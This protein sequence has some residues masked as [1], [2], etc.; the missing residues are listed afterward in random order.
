MSKVVLVF[1]LHDLLSL[2]FGHLIQR[3]GARRPIGHP[4]RIEPYKVIALDRIGFDW[5]P[6]ENYWMD[7]YQQ[8]KLYLQQNNGKMPSRCINGQKNPLG[9]WCETQVENYRQFNKGEKKAYIS[10]EKISMLNDIGLVMLAC[11]FSA[12]YVLIA[13]P[14]TDF[15]K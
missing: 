6:R 14:K 7:M 3:L 8:L 9:Q 12:L 2:T 1:C 11:L 13:M 4:D 10:E 5:Q 15:S